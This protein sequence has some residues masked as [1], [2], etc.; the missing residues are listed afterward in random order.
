[1]RKRINIITGISV[2]AL[3]GS[4]F[5]GCETKSSDKSKIHINCTTYAEYDWANRIVGDKKDKFEINYLLDKGVD[6]HSFQPTAQDVTK[7]STSE[8]FLGVGGESEKWADDILKEKLNKDME[9]IK[10]MD[11]LGDKAKEEEI[12]EGMQEEDEHDHDHDKEDK[13]HKDKD[14]DDKK[15]D[16]EDKHDDKKEDKEDKHDDE[17]EYDEHVWL[18]LKNAKIFVK[19]IEEAIEKQ[20]EDNKDVYKKNCDE[21]IKELEKL[22]KEYEE[23][24]KKVKNKTIVVGDRF[25]FR[26]L[27]DDYD[28]KYYAAF[29]GCSAETEAS[30][31]TIKFL[32]SKMDEIK[33]NKIFTLEKSDKKIADTVLK[34]TK[35]KKGDIIELDSIQ[36]VSKEKIEG[37]YSYINAMKSNLEALK[38]VLK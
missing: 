19:K 28:I 3:M 25:P 6:M 24:I 27:V 9:V 5:V 12:V 35:E 20:D 11:V 15:E 4:L 22:D 33:T 36:S 29:V 21:Y 17:K 26:Y 37:D 7:V 8:I 31:E 30:F 38:K 13:D 14:H 10:I 16:K 34:N 1:M 23:S 18:S 32:A 2:L